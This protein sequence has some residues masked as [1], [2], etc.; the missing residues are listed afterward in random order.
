MNE[1]FCCECDEPTGRAG[2]GDDSI[3][4]N[5]VPGSTE[6][7]GPLCSLCCRSLADAQIGKFAVDMIVEMSED[8]R[9]S[10]AEIGDNIRDEIARIEDRFGI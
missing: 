1:E 8:K 10:H 7:I 3:F 9:E 2:R 5:P 6:E 4:V